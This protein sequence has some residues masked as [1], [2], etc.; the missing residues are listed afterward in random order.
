[1][2]GVA[3]V[4]IGLVTGELAAAAA[5][6]QTR[7]AWRLAAW[8]SSF[9]ILIAQFVYD[10]RGSGSTA[11]STARHVA[12]AVALGAFGLA[13]VGPVRT[14]WGGANFWH[15][16]VLSV[17]VWPVMTGVPAFVV[18]FVAGSILG[19][20]ARRKPSKMSPG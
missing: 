16:A 15:T 3:Y 12:G 10:R 17:V 19:Q 20:V 18:A 8:L 13:V 5:S 4:T 11:G 2:V 1:M 9:A 14:H 6:I 7:N